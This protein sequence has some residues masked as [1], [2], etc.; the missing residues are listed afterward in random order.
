MGIKNLEFY[1]PTKIQFAAGL[2]AKLPSI[3]QALRLQSVLLVSDP[4]IIRAGVLDKVSQTLQQANIPFTC[5]TDIESDPSVASVRQG[6]TVAQQQQCDGVV[7]VGGGSVLDAAKAI[8]VMLNNPGKIEDYFGV[9]QIPEQA[10]PVIAI[11][12]TAGTGSEVTVWSVLSDHENNR[13]V[14]IGSYFNAPAIALLDPELSVGLPAAITAATGM[15]ALTHSIE[16]YVNKNSNTF[17]EALAEKSIQLI[18]DNLRLATLQGDNLEARGNMLLA[19]TLA[20]L[21]FNRIRLG[22]AHAFALPLG[23]Q[24]HIPHGLVNAIMLPPVMAFNLPANLPAYAKIAQLCGQVTQGMSLRDAAYQSVVAVRQLKQD[25][26]IT[27]TL[28]D[29]GVQEQHFDAIITEALLSGNVPVNPRSPTYNDMRLLLE[30]A[31]CGEV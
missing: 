18:A 7:A 19:S 13:K 24:F 4:G 8:A 9:D 3:V 10:A 16:S 22:L 21:S 1:S 20:G 31:L 26:G 27:Q 14:N 6:V 2:I 12:T 15:D 29:F 30:Q 28:A 23:N 11:P 5:Y 25:I 17:V